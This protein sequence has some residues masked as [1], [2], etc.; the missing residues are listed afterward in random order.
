MT[1]KARKSTLE[2]LLRESLSQL[3]ESKKQLRGVLSETAQTVKSIERKPATSETDGQ[4]P[5][6]NQHLL[7]TDAMKETL[8]EREYDSKARET[9]FLYNIPESSTPNEDPNVHIFVR[10]SPL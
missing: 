4:I 8:D 6:S 5:N 10:K 1:S 7:Y 9:F 2:Y 3:G